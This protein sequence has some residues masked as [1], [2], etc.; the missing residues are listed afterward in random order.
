MPF[1]NTGA[2]VPARVVFNSGTLD[3]GGQRIVDVDSLSLSME[4]GTNFLYVLGSILGQDLVRHSAKATLSGKI[5]SFSPE[6]DSIAFGSSVVGTPMELDVLD[7]QATLTNPILTVYD[8]NNKEVQYQFQ[9][10]LFK[11]TKANL[12]AEDFAEFDFELEALSM[13]ILYTA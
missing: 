12:K 9:S 2:N 7:G 1:N 8:R 10:A 3:F 4:Y 11:S 6:A 13:K 5:K